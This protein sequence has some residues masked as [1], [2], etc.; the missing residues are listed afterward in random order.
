MIKFEVATKESDYRRIRDIAMIIW[1]EHFTPIIGADQVEYMLGKYQSIPAIKKQISNGVH[2][3]LIREGKSI[4]G[5]FAYYKKKETLF[6]SKIY[7]LRS[8][9]G[10]GIGK[11]VFLFI[12]SKAKILGRVSLSLTV[13]KMNSSAIKAYQKLGFVT[14][15]DIVID[16]GNGYVMDDYVM[17]KKLNY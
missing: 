13:N 8:E 17:E 6:I 11:Y 1:Q 7:I 15:K 16:I 10:K 3:F 2:Y 9:R 4:V 5:Y 12:A 14:I